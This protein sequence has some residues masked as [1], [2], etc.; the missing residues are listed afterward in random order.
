MPTWELVK[1]RVLMLQV[2]HLDIPRTVTPTDNG[3]AIDTS[4]ASLIAGGASTPYWLDQV[5]RIVSTY[6]YVR[7]NFTD[8]E[9]LDVPTS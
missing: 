4:A 7:G 3:G 1:D 5:G 8:S 9:V 6:P 2:S